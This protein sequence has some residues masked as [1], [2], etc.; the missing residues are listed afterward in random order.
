VRA[1]VVIR[2]PRPEL[3]LAQFA[4]LLEADLAELVEVPV[5]FADRLM[6]VDTAVQR[7]QGGEWT[8]WVGVWWCMMKSA[9]RDSSSSIG[10][11]PFCE[12]STIGKARKA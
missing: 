9:L 4:A 1:D 12:G 5:Y 6:L 11:I 3:A 8:W 7:G 10:F 2:G